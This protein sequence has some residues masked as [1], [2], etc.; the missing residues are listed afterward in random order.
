MN[1]ASNGNEK[2]DVDTTAQRP[3]GRIA[4]SVTLL[5][6][7]KTYEILLRP[8]LK[9]ARVKI[10]DEVDGAMA[11]L[12]VDR[13]EG[14]RG[15]PRK[16]KPFV[17]NLP[18]TNPAPVSL[19]YAIHTADIPGKFNSELA[20]K[21][22]IVG[23]DRGKLAKGES[24]TLKDGRVVKPADLIPPPTPGF[25]MIVVDC[26]SENYLDSLI[27]NAR[28]TDYHSDSE[29]TARFPVVSVLHMTPA[30]VILTDKYKT[31][32]N[33]FAPNVE[34]IIL[35]KENCPLNAPFRSSGTNQLRLHRLHPEIFPQP[36]VQSA[37]ALPLTQVSGLPPKTRAG[38]SLL[39]IHIAPVSI[40]GIDS[41]EVVAPLPSFDA[42]FDEMKANKL[43][44]PF[45]KYYEELR[46][47]MEDHHQSTS[48]PDAMA[49][50]DPF[51]V[52]F[53]GT[54]S[55][56]PS[57]YRN[58]LYRAPYFHILS[59]MFHTNDIWC[60]VSSTFVEVTGFGGIL[61]DAGEG[62]LGQLLRRFG[63]HVDTIIR[64][65][66]CVFVSH[67]HADHHLGLIRILKR[68]IMLGLT[69][70]LLIVGPTPYPF[71]LNELQMTEGDLNWTFVDNLDV[72]Y[73]PEAADVQEAKRYLEKE[74][75]IAEIVIVP[76][77]HCLDACG[78]SIKHKSGWKIVYVI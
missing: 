49:V 57:K 66:K 67:M 37:P 32:M 51:A 61:F 22:G 30:S 40:Q 13:K 59:M 74:L 47:D 41:A 16:V 72:M 36:F 8:Q 53:L 10:P 9:A 46:K 50:E 54:G 34:H 68:R 17:R 26:P 55:A 56:M 73:H 75:G 33:R 25:V 43:Y 45:L 39:K 38:E 63:S 35:N 31:W 4:S 20:T 28:W 71:W 42:V 76:V 11:M 21:L 70:K 24:V 5:S 15:P 64:E 6:D 23:A 19:C 62:T 65:L 44:E 14:P 27:A 48:Q 3:V 60:L 78:I 7:N 29:S 18:L 52:T 2:M 1:S 58:G 77:I 69:D 12:N